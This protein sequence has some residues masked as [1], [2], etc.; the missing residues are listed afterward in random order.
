MVVPNASLSKA[1]IEAINNTIQY[2]KSK[3]IDIIITGR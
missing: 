3:G 2:G 1:Q